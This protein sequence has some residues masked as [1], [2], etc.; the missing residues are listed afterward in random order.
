M[1]SL[2]NENSLVKDSSLP[3]LLILFNR[4]QYLKESI[5]SINDIKPK[6][7]YIHIDGPR[8]KDDSE[9]IEEILN[10]IETFDSDIKK[11][12]LTQNKNLGC[13]LGMSTA[14]SWF[15]QKEEFGIILEDDCIPN[16]KFYSYCN[17]LLSRY[18]D[19]KN[20]FM[21]AGDNGG[22]IVPKKYFNDKQ[23]MSVPIPLIWGW[24]T[25]KDRWEQYD[26]GKPKINLFNLYRN[27]KNFKWLERFIL[28]RYFYRLNNYKKLNT[29]DINLFYTMI[30]L[31]KN[32]IIPKEN[33]VKNIGFDNQATHTKET[34]FRSNAKTYNLELNDYEL[35]HSTKEMNSK[36]VYLLQ[37]N[38]NSKFVHT[39]E[40]NFSRLVYIR[41]RFNY[42]FLS[43]VSKMR[44]IFNI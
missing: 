37:S 2:K 35:A 25:W 14:I 11:E 42:I 43:I 17:N 5:L 31:G 32:C 7:L 41:G 19:D 29:W 10:L 6:K 26:Y 38:L 18:K 22:E 27:L 36:I 16:K 21:I 24:A 39:N 9:K 28:I 34:T 33:L 13:G 4:P 23:I 15:F 1:V 44:K 12:I 20:I 30:I 40:L 8:N 3:V